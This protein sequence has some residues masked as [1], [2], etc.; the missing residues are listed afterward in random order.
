MD[1]RLVG[2]A[3]PDRG[4]GWAEA[5]DAAPVQGAPLPVRALDAVQAGQP[6]PDGTHVVLVDYREG[7]VYRYFV[8]QNGEGWGADD[9]EQRTADWQFQWF[10]PDG[11]INM[12]ENTARCQRCHTSRSDRDFLY[13]F[14][15][16]RRFE[17]K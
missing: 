9:P 6:I 2:G 14:N 10:K 11:T 4:G 13:T 17:L 3:L 8:M 5:V 1:Q 16:M 15:D 12:E 7:E